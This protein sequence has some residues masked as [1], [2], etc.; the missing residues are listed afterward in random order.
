VT[1]RLIASDIDGTILRT[2]NTI[3]PRTV[4]ALAAAEDAGIL[5]VLCSGRPPR[6]MKPIADATGHHGLAI[7]ANGALLYDLHTEEVVE[8]FLWDHEIAATVASEL[9]AA[10]PEVAFAV[11]RH[12]GFAFEPSY[13]PVF[14]LPKGV[15]I[16]ELDEL[17]S[18]P[19]VKL[20][21]RHPEMSA[22]DL[23]A[24]AHEAIADLGDKATT[25]YSMEGGLLEIAAPGV[26]KAF[27]LEKVA[28]GHGIVAAEVV[29]FGDMPN[30]IPMLS[31][32]G[33]GVAVANA[34]EEAKAVADEV[35]LS[36]DDDGV[37]VVIERLLDAQ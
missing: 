18:A 22:G 10:I 8:S 25:T 15:E 9:R 27:A 5:V 17:L 4:A 23:L 21:A 3:S 13:M 20:L 35:T 6:W 12:D 30:D 31:W 33:L 36:N 2:D 26:S 7:C 1:V 28:A 16:G 29:A 14:D 34:H 24:A 11:E 37:A 19:I 32:A